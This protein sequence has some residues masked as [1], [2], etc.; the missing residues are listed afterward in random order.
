M[1]MYNYIISI[2]TFMIIYVADA[3]FITKDNTIRR[4]D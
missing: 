2:K 4:G 1:Q 3:K